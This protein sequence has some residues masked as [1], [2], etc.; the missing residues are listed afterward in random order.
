[1]FNRL[2]DTAGVLPKTI[3]YATA[4]QKSSVGKELFGYNGARHA[5][6]APMLPMNQPMGSA[7]GR[8]DRAKI[9]KRMINEHASCAGAGLGML[10][11][12]GADAE[13]RF[14]AAAGAVSEGLSS[15]AAER[16]GDLRVD[17]VG[18][19]PR[20]PGGGASFYGGDT[21]RSGLGIPGMV[22]DDAAVRGRR[23]G[24]QKWSSRCMASRR[25]AGRGCTAC[26]A[27]APG[28]RSQRL[29]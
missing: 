2:I 1:M 22:P 23:G 11:W 13:S 9:G 12:S 18:G 29:A 5:P 19:A 3:E 20:G 24:S 7:A 8:T 4:A 14:G 25:I 10:S 21:Q 6:S 26:C 28:A 27:A 15:F 16:A 17:G